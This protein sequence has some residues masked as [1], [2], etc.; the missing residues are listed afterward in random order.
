[1]RA[2]TQGEELKLEA[3]KWQCRKKQMKERGEVHDRM[4][5]MKE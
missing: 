3:N 1:M 4:N 2:S 5:R